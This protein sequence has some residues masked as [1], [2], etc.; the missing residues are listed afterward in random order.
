MSDPVQVADTSFLYALFSESDTFHARA[1][2]A[3]GSA[4]AILVPSEIFSE[5]VSLIQYRAGFR[6]AKAAGDWMR[7]QDGLQVRPATAAILDQAW[8]I[9]RQSKGR[10]SY[11]DAVVLAWSRDRRTEPL[12]FDR[13]LLR[14]RK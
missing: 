5:T 11:P 6:K 13:A 8:A 7:S 1:L 10:L 2:E 9:F 4:T 14:R 12:A 3:A